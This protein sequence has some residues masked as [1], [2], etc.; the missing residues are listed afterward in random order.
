MIQIN[1][2]WGIRT[3]NMSVCLCKSFM[4][5]GEKEWRDM[6]HYADI[7]QALERLIDFAIMRGIDQ[8]SWESVIAEVRQTR[9]EIE[10]IKKILK[11]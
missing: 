10:A 11:G 7:N 5:K 1:K 8:G 2:R 3:G 6:Y 9:G 4:V